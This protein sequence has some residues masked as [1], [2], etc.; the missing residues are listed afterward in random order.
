VGGM[1]N[2]VAVLAVTL[3]L[4]GGAAWLGLDAAR[5]DALPADPTAA[6]TADL[7]VPMWS[8]RRAPDAIAI[9]VSVQQVQALVS[10]TLP[11]T[12]HCLMVAEGDRVLGE[13]DPDT[14]F[15]PASTQKIFTAA[16]ALNVLGPDFRYTTQLFSTAAPGPDGAIPDLFIVGAGDPVLVTPAYAAT[17]ADA[18]T[19]VGHVRTPFEQFAT[20]LQQAGVRSITGPIGVDDARYDQLR[21][22]RS[23]RPS[24][25]ETPAVVGP[26]GALLV[27]SGWTR[28]D[29][30]DEQSGDPAMTAGETLA[31]TLTDVGITVAG[32]VVRAAPPAGTMPIAELTSPPLTEI[33]GSMLRES[34]NTIA[35]LITRELGL[36]VSNTPTTEAGAQAIVQQLAALGVPTAGVALVDG[37]GLDRGATATCRAL[38]ATLGLAAD[39]ARPQFAVL[40]DGLAVAGRSGTLADALEG[41]SLVDRLRAKTGFIEGVAGLA[42]FVDRTDTTPTRRLRFAFLVNT[43]APQQTLLSSRIEVGGSITDWFLRAL[44][45]ARLAPA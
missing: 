37:S 33:L 32:P 4:L 20:R 36:R 7:A 15:T 16:A 9:E 18:A 42:G 13:S 31:Q 2:V 45:P 43:P 3:A 40:Y 29:G 27:D 39:P 6:A 22:L 25:A 8:L 30:S 38:L 14:P 34:D 23:W 28:P 10:Q 26:I 21:V 17:L 5:D 11:A 24:Y 19:T 44:D 41:T 1:R 35:E 12:P